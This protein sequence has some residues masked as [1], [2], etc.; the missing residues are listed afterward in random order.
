MLTRKALADAIDAY[1]DEITALQDSKRETYAEYRD[2]L[3]D[4]MGKDEIKVELEAT[5]A[6][7]KRRRAIR[8][9][10]EETVDH[11]DA[12]VDEIFTEITAA[13]APRATRV[14]NIEQFDA[15]TGEIIEPADPASAGAAADGGSENAPA[16]VDTSSTAV[17]MDAPNQKAGGHGAVNATGA[18][19]ESRPVD[20]NVSNHR[21]V[22]AAD[23]HIAH[24]GVVRA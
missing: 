13:R 5:K 17:R 24:Q 8:E 14:E 21:P 1:D 19:V 2:E 7:I 3:A 6:A 20:T 12:L 18:G 10:G 23:K 11:R 22:I 15:E 4:R 16:T 9:K